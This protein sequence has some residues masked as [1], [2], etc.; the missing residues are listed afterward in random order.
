MADNVL[1]HASLSRA[2]SH[3]GGR[4]SIADCLDFLLAKLVRGTNVNNFTKCQRVLLRSTSV[5][6]DSPE[7]LE[8]EPQPVLFVR[9]AECV[10]GVLVDDILTRSEP[11]MNSLIAERDWSVQEA[12]NVL[13][14]EDMVVASRS[15]QNVDLR[16][17]DHNEAQARVGADGVPTQC[18]SLYS[19]YLNRPVS[20]F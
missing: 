10:I 5:L 17:P 13:N 14:D 18:R 9:I 8:S 11:T 16:H 1:I 7:S 6:F 15:F 20:E 4:V 19:K 3:I 2:T 12:M